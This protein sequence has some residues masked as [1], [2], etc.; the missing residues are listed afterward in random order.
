MATGTVPPT[1]VPPPLPA[2]LEHESVIKRQLGRTSLH[3]RLV[4]LSVALA[5]WMIAV[6]VLLLAAVVADHW[7]PGGLGWFG[8]VL[9]S[10]VLIGGSVH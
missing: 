4:D 10:L 6:L 5:T 8:R 2:N 7:I 9:A 3:V 1:V